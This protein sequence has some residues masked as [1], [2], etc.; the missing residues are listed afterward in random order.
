MT[1]ALVTVTSPFGG[2]RQSL[3]GVAVQQ[4]DGTG[5]GSADRR[6]PDGCGQGLDLVAGLAKDAR[7][8]I[9]DPDGRGD[10]LDGG[11]AEL[12]AVGAG[13]WDL[14][15]WR[16]A[17]DAGA[18]GGYRSRYLA[19]GCRVPGPLGRATRAHLHNREPSIY[20]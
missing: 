13:R 18:G 6:T 4:A 15:R 2:D 20:L 12:T 8:A 14:G 19:A 1:P 17:G 7:E 10:F 11:V 3:G 9:V 16:P 5:N